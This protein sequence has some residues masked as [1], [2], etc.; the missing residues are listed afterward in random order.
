MEKANPH[1]ADFA[2]LIEFL[3]RVPAV[4]T[5]STPSQ[6][7][8]SGYD[9]TEWWLK[10][11]LDIDHPLAWH[12][13]QEL[14]HVLNYLSTTEKLPTVFKPVSPPSYLNGGPRDY[15]SWV[16]ECRIDRMAPD[17]VAQWLEAR[18]PQPVEDEDQWRDDDED[19]DGLVPAG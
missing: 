18:L 17:T 16:I 12:A 5:N 2:P 4:Q 19:D 1:H 6:G 7:F 8:G 10:F 13:V 15:L 14:G 11:S 9:E 3:K